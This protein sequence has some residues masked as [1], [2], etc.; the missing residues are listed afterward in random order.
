MEPVPP[1]V[2]ERVVEN[3]GVDVGHVVRANNERRR[4]LVRELPVLP[5]ELALV[6]DRVTHEQTNGEQERAAKRNEKH[7]VDGS[8]HPGSRQIGHGRMKI[9]PLRI[10][11]KG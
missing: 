2:T 7:P 4:G 8:L 3:D 1:V 6:F 11:F 10:F 5:F 9:V